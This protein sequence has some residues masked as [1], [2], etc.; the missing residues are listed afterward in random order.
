MKRSLSPVVAVLAALAALVVAPS[1]AADGPD[2][3]DRHRPPRGP[4]DITGSL[5]GAPYEI[6]VPSRWNGTLVMYA[7]GYRDLADH[8]GEVDD[9]SAQAFV[10]DATEELMLAQGYAVAG[11]AYRR[12]GWA[13]EEGLRDT[14]VLHDHFRRVVGK[15]RTTLLA[16][17][18]MGSVIAFESAEQ[19][20]GTYDGFLPSC[21]VGAGAPRAYDASL[22]LATAYDA[23]FGWP[24]A[25]GTPADVRDDIDF[26]TEVFPVLYGQLQAPGGAAKF[27][28]IRLA[29]GGV[30]GP[31]WPISVWFFATEG[32]A[33]LE[34]RAGGQVAQ[35]RDHT[36]RLTDADRG[37]LAGI[38]VPGEQAD[39]W[40]ADM[41]ASRVR[42]PHRPR[43]YVERY[44]DYSGRIADP[45]LTLDTTTDALVPPAHI[46]KYNETVREAGRS[47]LVANAWTSGV[48]HCAFT[49][50]QLVTS[51]QALERWV[52]TG[53]RP[54]P[55]PA[56]QGFVQFTPPAWPQP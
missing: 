42:A 11:S 3:A 47:R 31:E 10:D 44:A 25:W 32:R 9:R 18:S 34:R 50:R 17:F 28:F 21:A 1:A 20:R 51:V 39:A 36:Y 43:A 7:H 26:E 55:L 19:H 45:V 56:D 48:G 38:G 24:A 54:G 41:T 40:L 37:Y 29:A 46:S 8:P 30:Q 35:N 12:N 4:L 2:G 53:R 22:A 15:P 13:V 52:R 14:K 16:G 23:V 49:P 33:E 27:E 6:R 5:D